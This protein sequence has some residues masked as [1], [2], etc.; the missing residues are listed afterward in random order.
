MT[1]TVCTGALYAVARLFDMETARKIAK[2]IEY[3]WHST[4]VTHAS[5][6]HDHEEAMHG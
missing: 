5:S 3:P 6:L 4:H 1:L 2:G